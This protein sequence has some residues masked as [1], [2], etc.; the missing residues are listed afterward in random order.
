VRLPIPPLSQ[1]VFLPR[2]QSSYP[3]GSYRGGG[4]KPD[5]VRKRLRRYWTSLS[6][7]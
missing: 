3:T 1:T 6:F 4:I 2:A 5:A 7:W